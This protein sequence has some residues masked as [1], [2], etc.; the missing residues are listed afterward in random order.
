MIWELTAPDVFRWEPLQPY[1]D[2]IVPW[3]Q[4][5]TVGDAWASVGN[6][7]L[8]EIRDKLGP[9]LKS[10]NE[11]SDWLKGLAIGREKLKF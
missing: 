2:Q 11:Q 5:G 9:P 1:F 10:K 8:E 4:L 7:Y 3:V 6:E